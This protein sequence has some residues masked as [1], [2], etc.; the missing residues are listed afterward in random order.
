MILDIVSM[1]KFDTFFCNEENITDCEILTLETCL[2]S[3]AT[4]GLAKTCL[5]LLCSVISV[6]PD[7]FL[8]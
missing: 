3:C 8:L 7:V 4:Y 5:F 2:I 1:A 6:I